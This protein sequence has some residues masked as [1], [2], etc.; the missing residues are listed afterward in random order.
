M[1]GMTAWAAGVA[2]TALIAAAD[3]GAAEETGYLAGHEPDTIAVVPQAPTPGSARDNADRA[4]FKATRGLKGSPRWKLATHDANIAISDLLN[5]FSCAVGLSLTETNAPAMAAVMRKSS[6]DLI[7]AYSAP[8]ELYKRQRPYLRDDG[9]ICEERSDVLDESYDYP[10]GHAT[11]GWAMGMM[12]AEAAPDR[13]AA[14]LARARAYGESR[15]VCGVHSASA[16]DGARAAATTVVTALDGTAAFR[17]DIAAA[18][19]QIAA[20]R[21]SSG[22]N[23]P[24]GCE[25]EAALIAKTPW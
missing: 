24:S 4:I 22:A 25:A 5:D 9:P 11:F 10:S 14:I 2:L 16:V 12:I 7:E 23:R 3:G 15:A 19:E 18:R 6:P 13:T 20:L 21:A 8:K 1:R 17:S